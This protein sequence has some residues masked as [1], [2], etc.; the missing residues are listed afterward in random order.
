MAKKKTQLLALIDPV[1]AKALKSKLITHE[2]T[3]RRWLEIRICEY[4]GKSPSPT[5]S[6][7]R[8]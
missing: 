1:L 2:L 8:R 6:R 4:V 3:Y 5:S 7:R